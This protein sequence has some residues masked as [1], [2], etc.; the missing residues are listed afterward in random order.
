MKGVGL[1]VSRAF[2]RS[3]RTL[4]ILESSEGYLRSKQ[5]DRQGF[6]VFKYAQTLHVPHQILPIIRSIRWPVSTIPQISSILQTTLILKDDTAE[7]VF[8]ELSRY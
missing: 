3:R 6:P 1:R 2:T 8:H 5:K 7:T 4:K